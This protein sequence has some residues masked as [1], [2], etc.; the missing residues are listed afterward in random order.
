MPPVYRRPLLRAA[1]AAAIVL[2]F[3]PWLGRG[4]SYVSTQVMEWSAGHH[5]LF[6]PPRSIREDEVRW[7]LRGDVETMRTVLREHD[8]HAPSTVDSRT[9]EYRV[10][11]GRLA[12]ILAVIAALALALG[13]WRSRLT[14]VAA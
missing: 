4:R 11:A 10:D 2:L 5:S 6:S 8:R 14:T 12:T 7:A 13:W 3:P 1:I 9:V